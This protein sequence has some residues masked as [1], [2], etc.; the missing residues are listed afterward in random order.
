MQQSTLPIIFEDNSSYEVH[1]FILSY[2]NLEAYR[3]VTSSLH[4]PENRF[5]IIGESK[6]GKTHLAKIWEKNTGA[7]F[8]KA[9]SCISN[10]LS[11]SHFILEDINNYPELEVLNLI[12]LAFENDVKLLLT[13]SSYTQATIPDLRSRINATYRA[14]IKDPDEDM[15]KVLIGKLLHDRQIKVNNNTLEYIA[16][17]ITRTYSNINNFVRG[18]DKISLIQKRDININFVKSIM[19]NLEI[20]SHVD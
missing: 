10:Y 4:W 7:I 6:S 14:I 16:S 1:D 8:L 20:I 15:T 5:I 19:E 17:R 12:N 3:S 13:T 18:I 9:P 11:K 2:S